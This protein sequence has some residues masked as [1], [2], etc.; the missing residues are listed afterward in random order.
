MKRFVI[1]VVLGV[2]VTQTVA[3]KQTVVVSRPG[4]TTVV[5]TSPSKT[6]VITSNG[7]R[8][9]VVVHRSFPVRR[10][11]P[12]VIVRPTRVA[13]VRPAVFIAPLFWRP[14]VVGVPTHKNVVWAGSEKL[15]RLEDWTEFTVPCGHR[16]DSM[17]MVLDGKAQ[18]EFAEVVFGNGDA[19]VIDFKTATFGPGHYALVNFKDGRKVDHV[20]VVARAQSPTTTITFKVVT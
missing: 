10:T 4:R 2:L 11:W 18:L 8:T 13:I 12:A 20:R 5:Q 6:A 1:A 14:V 16:G 19:Q 15:A 9:R 3:A 17:F 7:K